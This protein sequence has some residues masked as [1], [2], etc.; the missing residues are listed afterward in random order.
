MA[1]D[2][3]NPTRTIETEKSMSRKLRLGSVLAAGIVIALCGCGGGGSS[4][5]PPVIG[6]ELSPSTA[7]SIDQGQVIKFT[8]SVSNDSKSA[9]VSW[10]QTG[11]GGL[12]GQT[13]SAATYT[14]PT[15]GPAGTAS[16]TATSVTDPTKSFSVSIAITPA[17]AF[18]TTTLPAGMVN[19]PYNQTVAVT[20]GTGTLTY[21][22][23]SGALPAGLSLNTATGAITGTPTGATGTAS[24][25]VK[26][27][28]SSTAGPVPATQ[29]LTLLINPTAP[30]SIST[31]TFPAAVEGTA[32]TQTI[33]A[34]GYPPLSFSVSAGTLPAGLTLAS[35]TGV[36]SG[37]PTGPTGSSSFTIKVTDGN[38]PA[39]STSQPLSITVNPAATLTIKNTSLTNGNINAAYNTT[40]TTSGGIAPITW[41]ILSGSLPTGL[42]LNGSTGVLSGTPTESGVFSL[43]FQAADSSNPQQLAQ[44]ALDLTIDG[45]TLAITTTSLL[46]PLVGESYNQTLQFT[47]GTGNVTWS[48]LSGTLPAGLSLNSATGA[49][50]GTPTATSG[51]TSITFQLED[52]SAPTPQIQTQAINLTVTSLSSCGSGNESLLNGQYGISLTGFD[53]SGPVAMLASIT[54]DGTGKITSGV[55]DI[56]STSP[57][58]VQLNLPVTTASSSY[59]I[60]SDHRGCLTLVAGGVTRVFRLAASTI[61][62]GVASSARIVEFDTT[63]SNTVGLISIQNPAD[64]SNAMINGTY[65]FRVK[66]PL[67]T[68]A[69]GGFFAGVGAWN[70]SG[71]TVTG[72]GD[73]NSNGVVNGNASL[74]S[75]IT[76]SSGTYNITGPDGRG[77]LSFTAGASTIHLVLYVIDSTQLILMSSD[78]QSATSNLFSGVAG[79]QLHTGA[80]TLSG[81]TVLFGSGL[82]GTGT[83]SQVQAGVFTADGVSTFTYSG[84]QNSGGTPSTQTASG[85]YTVS[86]SDN[87]RILVTNTG[88]TT[89]ALIFYPLDV[90]FLFGISTDAH[91][92]TLDV[93]PHLS[94]PYSDGALTGA[95]S[96]ASIDPVVPGSGLTEGV[97][98]Y[99]GAGNVTGTF[100][101]NTNGSLS[102]GNAFTN[103]YTVVANGRAV[104][105]ASGTTKTV[106]YVTYIGKVVSFDYTSSNTNPTL[107]VGQP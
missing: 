37:T 105:P 29:P 5:P 102:L 17:P 39:Q 71:S 92:L 36:I 55:E 49:I 56:N 19:A 13:T 24:F 4:T 81:V 77:T 60:G 84:D 82:N 98:N 78:P 53:S 94:E 20:G 30:P 14:A 72:F 1:V 96:S 40:L 69:G 101:R 41:S 95:Y 47:G 9:G 91:V 74:A 26:V 57:S 93:E 75:P 12:S 86:S 25:A 43:T 3:G 59:S 8:A 80:S 62:A 48:V 27:T 18:T 83:S 79:I 85:T 16:V 63:G 23:S 64:F 21:S 70:L 65:A 52:Q 2:S 68:A 103:T 31:T 89:P 90:D 46:N 28:D 35:G 51:P 88:G 45:T 38:V 66:S 50:T 15:N 11:L 34:T 42:S 99:D 67:T 73:F 32:Y 7:Q 97:A 33:Q 107:V 22:I 87:G 76:L 106:S 104:S 61:K 58:G 54:A 6:V 10:S 100:E 44:K